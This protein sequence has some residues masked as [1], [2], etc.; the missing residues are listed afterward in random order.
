[1]IERDPNYNPSRKTMLSISEALG[2][3]PSVIFFPQE[4]VD[5]RMMLSNLVIFCMDSLDKTECEI[6]QTLQEMWLSTH[7][8]QPSDEPRVPAPPSE[9]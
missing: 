1:M 2:L 9:Q 7:P 3:P 5:K 4:E 6:L 8:V